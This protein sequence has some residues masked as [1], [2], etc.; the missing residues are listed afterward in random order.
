M[1]CL[2]PVFDMHDKINERDEQEPHIRAISNALMSR[3]IK[4]AVF[5]ILYEGNLAMQMVRDQQSNT[6]DTV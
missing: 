1:L 2:C 6:R 4:A 3:H 5:P